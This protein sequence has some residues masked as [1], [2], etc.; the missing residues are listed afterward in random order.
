[1]DSLIPSRRWVAL[2]T[3]CSLVGLT[4]SGGAHADSKTYALVEE[5]SDTTYR[6]SAKAGIKGDL[7]TPNAKAPA[8]KWRLKSGAD[9]VFHE[10]RLPPAGRDAKSLRAVRDY[11]R[12]RAS[13]SVGDHKTTA[14][15]DPR[16]RIIVAAG[17][18]E[19]VLFYSPNALLTRE[20]L[21]LLSSPADTLAVVAML[22]RTEVEVGEKWNPDL[23]VIQMLTD[24]E[25]ATEGKL[26]CELTSVKKNRARVDVKGSLKGASLG[27]VCEVELS[28]HV[29]FDLEHKHV[30]HF[31][32]ERQE[33]R[34]P[35]TVNPGLDVTATITVD[36]TRA[37]AKLPAA[38]R[39]PTDPT[40]QELRLVYRTPWGVQLK[41]D[42]GWH[43][44]SEDP[45]S[46]ILRLVKDGRLFAQCNLQNVAAIRPG[47]RTPRNQFTADIRR[48]LGERL[49]GLEPVR[50]VQQSP[51]FTYQAIA[52][53]EADQT[54]MQWL[55]Y[56]C[57]D[58]NGKQVSLVYSIAE[59]DLEA[60]ASIP[61]DQV[62]SIRFPTK[63]R[64]SRRK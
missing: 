32:F 23:W 20:N 18:R 41:H 48:T 1:M 37:K 10:R 2:V 12:A 38:D 24:T 25:A 28:G 46:A 17:R 35:G 47:T 16:C 31:E 6:V 49:V 21:D 58:Q 64:V 63:A 62:K 22:P 19:G 43:V 27:A 15:L 5:Q 40:V 42:R 60:L 4:P 34:S 33:K 53:G 55:Y 44:F 7:I 39:I 14:R 26:A 9:Y 59:S 45:K 36:R 11:T 13:T 8:S 52:K 54:K 29:I 30:S 51:V 56:L 61:T 3:L 57:T 50:I